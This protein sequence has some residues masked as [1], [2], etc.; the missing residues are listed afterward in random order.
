MAAVGLR[1]DRR[2][3]EAEVVADYGIAHY[4]FMPDDISMLDRCDVYVIGDATG[5]RQPATG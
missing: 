3:G 2:D 5:N 4:S 1:R